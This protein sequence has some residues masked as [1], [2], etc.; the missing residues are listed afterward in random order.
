MSFALRPWVNDLKWEKVIEHAASPV[1]TEWHSTAERLTPMDD[2]DHKILIADFDDRMMFVALRIDEH[3]TL[4]KQLGIH[5]PTITVH[6]RKALIGRIYGPISESD[7][8][9]L[10][11]FAY[12]KP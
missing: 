5:G 9:N 8:E 3:P 2:D 12:Q 7:Y 6:R 1:V 11:N 4:V 10:C